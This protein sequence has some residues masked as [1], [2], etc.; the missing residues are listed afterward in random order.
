M[1]YYIASIQY[2]STAM[3]MYSA[4][5]YRQSSNTTVQCYNGTLILYNSTTVQSYVNEFLSS[6]LILTTV[7]GSV[8]L[9]DNLRASDPIP[10]RMGLISIS[11][12]AILN[13]CYLPT[14]IS[15]STNN[16]FSNKTDCFARRASLSDLTTSSYQKQLR[17]AAMASVDHHI[18]ASNGRFYGKRGIPMCLAM[19]QRQ[20]RSRRNAKWHAGY[21]QFMTRGITW[22]QALKHSCTETFNSFGTTSL[23]DP[24]LDT[25]PRTSV[26]YQSPSNQGKGNSECQVHSIEIRTRMKHPPGAFL[27]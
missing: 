14:F 1:Q 26:C 10:T 25:D 19:M 11:L 3:V 4:W 18:F 24:K 7:G 2:Y 27:H 13:N 23:G 6:W 17:T 21:Q 20:E 12:W 8:R 22:N 15:P 9:Q 16:I 5:I